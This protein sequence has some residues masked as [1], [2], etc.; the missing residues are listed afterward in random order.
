MTKS[1]TGSMLKMVSPPV[2]VTML[3][4]TLL[5]I[6]T[7]LVVDP[8]ANRSRAHGSPASADTSPGAVAAQD[9]ERG[10]VKMPAGE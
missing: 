1:R 9:I 8:P 2:L 7:A 4:L 6:A 3:F 5:L 10:L